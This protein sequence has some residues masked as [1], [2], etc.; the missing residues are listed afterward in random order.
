MNF[1]MGF[2]SVLL[3]LLLLNTLLY[4]S[5]MYPIILSERGVFT[6]GSPTLSEEM[7][8]Y[9]LLMY[10]PDSLLISQSSV[11]NG[12][13]FIFLKLA[14][15]NE[16]SLGII[17]TFLKSENKT[18]LISVLSLNAPILILSKINSPCSLLS[19]SSFIK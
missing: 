7:F 3:S 14:E 13:S 12:F 15:S 17:I 19:P 8:P 6:I 9:T 16:G 10:S 1:I 2:F 4:I 18:F 5:L 11:N